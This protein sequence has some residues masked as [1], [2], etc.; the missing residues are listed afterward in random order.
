MA[1]EK[2]NDKEPQGVG[3]GPRPTTTGPSE[4]GYE[5]PNDDPG[6]G[7]GDVLDDKLPEAPERDWSER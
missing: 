1:H 2:R 7:Q 4:R 3:K 5:R 6:R